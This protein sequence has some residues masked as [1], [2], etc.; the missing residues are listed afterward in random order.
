MN[1]K[2]ESS[3]QIEK[4]QGARIKT[5]NP[6]GTK[7]GNNSINLK[8]RLVITINKTE[9]LKNKGKFLHLK[10]NL[11]S[12]SYTFLNKLNQNFSIVIFK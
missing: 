2:F 6:A 7:K 1:T 12:H 5:K 9:P 8:V 4:K 11:Y 3:Q 10:F